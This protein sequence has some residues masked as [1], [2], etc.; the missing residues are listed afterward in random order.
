MKK[1]FYLLLALP[2]FVACTENNEE[3]KP[4]P[5]KKAQLIL[6]SNE[7][8]NFKAEGGQGTI[9]YTL[10]NAR[11]D[12]EFEA[13]CEAAWIGEFAF[14]EDITFTVAENDAEEAREAKITVNYAE[15]SMEVT[16]KQA[17]KKVSAAPAL[18]ITSENPMEFDMNGGIG[19]I[20][21]TIENPVQGVSLTASANVN[22]IS[23]VTVQSEKI[24]FQV[25]ANTG[26]AREGV[27]T[28]TYG[29]LE[30]KITVKQAEYVAP[31]PVFTFNPASLEVSFEG[32]AQSVAYTIENAIEGAEVVATCEAAWV[33]NLV[34]A[35]G[36]MTFDV[37]ANE[38]SLRQAIIV[39]TY[40]DYAFEYVIKQLPANYNPGLNYLA[41]TV[42]EAW[43]DLKE[44][45]HV[46]NVTFV[47]HDDLLGDMQTVIS[48]YIEE[49][50]VHS[51]VSGSYSSAEGTI[52]L[53]N[54][55]RNG[56][57]TYRANASL[58]T[59]ISDASFVVAVDTDAQ[60][61]SFDGSFQAGNDIVA[62]SYSGAVRGMDL[63]GNTSNEVNC[64][65]W[66]R[67]DKNYQDT[68]ECIFT[69]RSSDNALEI[70]FHIQHSGGT[71]V[72]PAGTYEVAP[73]QQLGDVLANSSTVTYNS[74]KGSLSSGSITVT[75][76][77]GQYLFE[78]D[79]TDEYGRRFTGS[80]AGE[81]GNG[82]V[83]P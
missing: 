1:L 42:V 5:Q 64:T 20:T 29:M 73:Y 22:W 8:M 47:E 41:F 24:I 44:G 32:G 63:T 70:M 2:L 77:R 34:A 3:P 48:F 38:E 55:S 27:I 19:T 31:A 50:N 67:F 6:T 18:V 57:S 79:I 60:T 43:A 28:A 82:G 7:V 76:L 58:A 40:G 62:L 68:T 17:G 23:Q 36:T 39:L 81:L 80:Y 11:E 33:S 65:E 46:W 53:N 69:G 56:Y 49:A 83:N 54:A 25:A 15:A 12:V 52:L 51:L 30:E 21:Y 78:F 16:V 9:E 13:V 37:A 10:V 45:G 35:N 74:V 75:H 4:E 61:I 71:K 72:I 14:G 59:D 66:K 26:A